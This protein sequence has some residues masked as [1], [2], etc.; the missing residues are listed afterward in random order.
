MISSALLLAA[1]PS[2]SFLRLVER[3][4]DASVH[5]HWAAY[6]DIDWESPENEVHAEDPRWDVQAHWDPMTST[7]WYRDQPVET[8]STLSLFRHAVLLKASIEFE[9]VLTEGLLRFA[10]RLSNGHPAFR[11]VYHEVTE[12]AQHSMM[13]QELI[14][15]TG[16]DPQPASEEA[17]RLF[18]K[19]VDLA[20]SNPVLFF[21]AV[22]SGEEAF[23]HIQRRQMVSPDGHPLARQI[24]RIHVAEEARHVSFARAFL[25]DLIPR[26]S[27]REFRSLRYEVPFLI[28]WTSAHLYDT[29]SVLVPSW[30]IPPDVHDSMIRSP[31]ATDL[32]RSSTSNVV[33]L[34][35][36]LG[37]IDQRVS[38]VWS[39][40]GLDV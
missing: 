29:A 32:R 26:L 15:R 22:L 20:V 31:Q 34:C 39:R 19:F 2:D 4:S 28:E 18:G 6:E 21:L 13:F 16:F 27:R 40:I 12:E 33:S 23:D 30:S 11:Y 14:N 7:D 25:R 8:R 9:A 36:E 1:E 38:A 5:R 17:Q 37:L 24:G 10:S 35:R 3:L